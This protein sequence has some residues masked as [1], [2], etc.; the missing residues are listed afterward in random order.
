VLTF[1]SGVVVKIVMSE[2]LHRTQLAQTRTKS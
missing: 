1:L 2:T